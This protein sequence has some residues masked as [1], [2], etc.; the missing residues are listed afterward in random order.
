MK[1]ILCSLFVLSFVL[2]SCTLLDR[3]QTIYYNEVEL[4]FQDI[5][6]MRY[7]FEENEPITKETA[8]L[9][10]YGMSDTSSCVYWTEN[11]SVWHLNADCGYMSNS[12]KIIYGSEAAAIECGKSKICSLCEKN[13]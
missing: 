5:T 12:K 13:K 3:S 4:S 6:E 10:A 8:E 11:G 2:S 1:R 9:V 7:E